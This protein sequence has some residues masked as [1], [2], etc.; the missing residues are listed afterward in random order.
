VGYTGY[1]DT[2]GG[3]R[4]RWGAAVGHQESTLSFQ[5][6][7]ASGENAGYNAGLY[8]AWAGKSTFLNAVLGYGRYRNDAYGA[9]GDLHFNTKAFSGSLELGTHI[10]RSK[11]GDFTP[12]ASLSL[13]HLKNEDD[14]D[15]GS[16]LTLNSGS[17]NVY[18]SALGMR[19]TRRMYDKSGGLKGGWEAGLAWL[20]QFGDTDFDAYA[21]YSAEVPG[22]FRVQTT[23]LDGNSVQVRLGAYGRIYHNLVGFAGYQGTFGS[24]QKVN[25]VNAG[26]GYQF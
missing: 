3:T 12:Y 26:V 24:S 6:V 16:G 7:N 15:S 18:S 4:F 10:S 1:G 20:H 21:G 17:S 9:S 5:D 19:Y 2:Y 14:R 8:A 13:T 11:S 22:S 25:A 23:P